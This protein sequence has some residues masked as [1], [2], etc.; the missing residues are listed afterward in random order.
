MNS[1]EQMGEAMLLAE[2]GK[3]QMARQAANWLA[4]RLNRVASWLRGD[5]VVAR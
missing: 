4:E 2:Q 3:Q 1:F 5:A